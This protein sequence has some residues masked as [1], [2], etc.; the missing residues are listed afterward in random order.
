ML[1]VQPMNEENK[2]P[3]DARQLALRVRVC[4]RDGSRY[5]YSRARVEGNLISFVRGREAAKKGE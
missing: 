4:A 5:V 2:S 1:S 3:L